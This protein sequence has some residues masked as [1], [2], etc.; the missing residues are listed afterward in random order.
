MSRDSVRPLVWLRRRVSRSELLEKYPAQQKGFRMPWTPE[1][2][3]RKHNKDLTPA[4]A[5][6]AAAVANETL[7]RT[8]DEGRAVRTGNAV[9]KR[10]AHK[11]HG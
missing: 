8:G 2:F 9:A 10:K 6:R 11:R 3:R 5:K 7:R 1:E 4:Q